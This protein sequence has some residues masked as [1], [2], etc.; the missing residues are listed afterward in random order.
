[1]PKWIP[2]VRPQWHRFAAKFRWKVGVAATGH[3]KAL[4]QPDGRSAAIADWRA[5]PDPIR[6]G[7]PDP[8]HVF[9]VRD[10][11]RELHRVEPEGERCAGGRTNSTDYRR[12][13][14]RTGNIAV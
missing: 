2:T 9:G 7:L 8:R 10:Y 5:G 1:M 6:C 11:R 12:K 13:A 4:E 3:R 14:G